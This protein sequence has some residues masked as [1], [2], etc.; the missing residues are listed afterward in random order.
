M[1]PLSVIV[2]GPQGCGKTANAEKL[3]VGFGLDRV[4]EWDGRERIPSR[5][6]L[7]LTHDAA[8]VDRVHNSNRYTFEAAMRHIRESAP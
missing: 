8:A 3:R 6:V 4:M 1:T 2:C 7:V 5:G